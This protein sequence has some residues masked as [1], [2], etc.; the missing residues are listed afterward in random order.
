M[1]SSE[2]FDCQ[3]KRYLLNLP[4]MEEDKK[5]AYIKDVMRIYSEAPEYM[6]VSEVSYEIKKK[7]PDLYPE[8][9]YSKIKHHYNELLLNRFSEFEKTVNESEDP[10]LSAM[11][12]SI[13]CNYIDFGTVE[14]VN[15]DS[16]NELLDEYESQEI[17]QRYY[18][19]L[20]DDLSKAKELLYITDNCGEVV[21]DKL[22]IKKIRELYP[23]LHVTVMVRGGEAIND[24]SMTDAAQV[25]LGE[26][27]D[28]TDNGEKLQATIIRRLP[29]DRLE[30]LN[31]ADVIIAKGQANAEHMAGC[32]Y[33]VYYLFLCK[34]QFFAKKYNAKLMEAVLHKER[35]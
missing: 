9:D 29:K 18:E 21:L 17:D 22:V 25:G 30:Y 4:D 27:A 33:N 35:A 15:E 8:K 20:R 26:V 6:T 12:L 16:L 3:I 7:Y 24:A 31:R 32:G 10:L 13:V 14:N 19:D 34:C 1:L 23:S 11:K 2:C 28:L 5:I